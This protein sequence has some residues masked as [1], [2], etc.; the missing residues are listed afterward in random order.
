LNKFYYF[1]CPFTSKETEL[2]DQQKEEVENIIEYVW[3]KGLQRTKLER[4]YLSCQLPES[5]IARRKKL[6]I[7]LLSFMHWWQN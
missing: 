3:D 5:S 6:D 2:C 1:Q 4:L 7:S